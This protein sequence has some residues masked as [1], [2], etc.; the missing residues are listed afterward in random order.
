M[1][2]FVFVKPLRNIVIHAITNII[3]SFIFTYESQQ[4]SE[5]TSYALT[6]HVL[7]DKLSPGR[8]NILNGT[9]SMKPQLN[10]S[11][12]IIFFFLGSDLRAQAER[13]ARFNGPVCF[14]SVTSDMSLPLNTNRTVC[15]LN[16]FSFINKK[17]HFLFR[18]ESNILIHILIGHTVLL[19][20]DGY[21][22]YFLFF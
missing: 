16:I 13:L 5:S 20:I 7:S 17:I 19:N 22:K 3:R 14:R 1:K 9:E 6:A 21:F 10:F 4:C 11:S 12:S 15:Q 18:Q 2:S 8:Q